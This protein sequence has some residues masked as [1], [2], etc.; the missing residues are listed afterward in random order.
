MLAADAPRGAGEWVNRQYA[1]GDSR[2]AYQGGK[3]AGVDVGNWSGMPQMQ[4]GGVMQ[5]PQSGGFYGMG[6]PKPYQFPSVGPP[7]MPAYA[8]KSGQAQPKQTQSQGSPYA[9]TG[10]YM[11]P[12]GQKPP[13]NIPS[14]VPTMKAGPVPTLPSAGYGDITPEAAAQGMGEWPFGGA[15]FQPSQPGLMF[16]PG[17]ST[18]QPTFYG[19]ITP[20][21]MDAGMDNTGGLPFQ[22]PQAAQPYYTTPSQTFTAPGQN[23]SQSL[24]QDGMTPMGDPTFLGTGFDG[25]LAYA[26]PDKRPPPFMQA[27]QGVDG[28]MSDQMNVGQRDAFIQRL[29]DMTRDAMTSQ[30]GGPIQ[31]NFPQLWQQSGDMVQNGWTNPLAGLFG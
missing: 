18:P 17:G 11:A 10:R 13:V 16:S 25:N 14:D 5:D 20:E 22:P 27:F 3:A 19:G 7:D 2:F 23:W 21:A 15:P 8:P 31:Y 1:Q 26:T 30:A 9:P 24:G 12:P 29:N 4:H 28:S 6:Q